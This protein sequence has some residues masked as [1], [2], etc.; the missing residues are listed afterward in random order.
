MKR[1]YRYALFDGEGKRL[2]IIENSSAFTI[3]RLRQMVAVANSEAAY[4]TVKK[5][6]ELGRVV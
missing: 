5:A 4:P 1:N 6:I 2:G 3:K